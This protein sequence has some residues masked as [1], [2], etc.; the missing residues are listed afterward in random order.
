MGH[1]M[2]TQIESVTAL[3][4][5]WPFAVALG[6]CAMLV[7]SPLAA[8]SDTYPG[9]IDRHFA[10]N[11][12]EQVTRC[13]ICHDTAAGG[14]ETANQPFADTLRSLGLS[15]GKSNRD[16]ATALDG[17]PEDLDTD[18]DGVPDQEELKS[19]GNPSG[20]ELSEGP[21][22]GCNGAHLA[23]RAPPRGATGLPA[24]SAL[25]ALVLVLRLRRRSGACLGIAAG[26]ATSF[27]APS[28][29]SEKLFPARARTCYEFPVAVDA[30]G[31]PQDSFWAGTERRDACSGMRAAAGTGAAGGGGN[32]GGTGGAG[33]GGETPGLGGNGGGTGGS[34]NTLGAGGTAGMT[35][36]GGSGMAGSGMDG[37]GGMGGSA[38]TGPLSDAC[39][40]TKAERVAVPGYAEAADDTAVVLA[41][42]RSQVTV[43][44]C[45]DDEYGGCH[46]ANDFGAAKPPDFRSPT[47]SADLLDH[48]R[49]Y[50]SVE[51]EGCDL[52]WIKSGQDET[53]SFLWHKLVDGE[54]VS[55]GEPMPIDAPP[56][57][58]SA[59]ECIR[60][61]IRH[62][63][64]AP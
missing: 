17:L 20:E 43:G 32:M 13:L 26:I 15:G 60:M 22:Y 5:R 12:A 44:G 34:A 46:G 59:L 53:Q 18:A 11:C 51:N 30:G 29:I 38:N 14:E 62:V 57:D 50:D 37:G 23:R 63:A 61:W 42:F 8:A 24:V 1:D 36:Q 6:V 54:N 31:V 64:G 39:A 25:V 21:G 19:C 47:L 55:C 48:F 45:Q 28:E 41:L 4:Q 56:V 40:T 16:L 33:A 35:G 27:C 9:V 10:G 52:I 58:G 2:D 49:P 7:R 3:L